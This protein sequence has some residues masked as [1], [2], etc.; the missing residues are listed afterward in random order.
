M[1]APRQRT[2][3]LSAL[4]RLLARLGGSFG[5]RARAERER[6]LHDELES[7]LQLDVDER[8][9]RGVP[10][11]EARR[12]AL[13]ALGGLEAT[14]ERVRDA[15][16][17][18]WLEDLLHDARFALR[19]FRRDRLFFAV[20]VLTFALGIG[21][22]TAIFAAFNAVLL[23]PLP[24]PDGDRLVRISSTDLRAGE[25]RMPVTP[26]DF[27][28]YRDATRSYSLMA[29]SSDGIF[30]FT[31]EG[32]PESIIGYRFAPEMFT[33][34][35]VHPALGRA[36]VAADGAHV[37]VLSDRLWRRRFHS[38]PGVVGRYIRLDSERY[39]VVGVMPQ[40]FNQWGSNE[41]WVPLVIGPDIATSRTRPMIR[42]VARLRP[43]ATVESARAELRT[44]AASLATA[45]PDTNAL[46]GAEVVSLRTIDSGDA[47]PALYVLLGAVV[48]V[49]LLTS[50]NIAGLSLARAS[51]RNREIALRTALGAGRGRIVRQLFTESVL[52]ACIGGAAGVVLALW[53]TDLL[54]RLFPTHT[55]NVH[56]PHIDHIPIDARVLLFGV[57][58]TLL[59]GTLAGLTPAIRGSRIDFGDMLKGGR[60]SVRGSRIRPVLVAAQIGLALV[61]SAGAGL[62]ILSAHAR[63]QRLGFD[64]D[65]VFTARVL[66]D[67]SRYPDEA[68]RRQFAVDL[69][70]RL[71]AT[72]DIR[73]SGL[74]HILPLCG[75]SSP[76][77][78]HTPGHPEE[79]HEAGLLLADAGYFSTMR[80][81]ILRGRS[82]TATDTLTAP[83]VALVDER[84]AR[85]VFGSIEVV[86]KRV[87][88][89]TAKEPDW[90]TIVG[91]VGDV[92]NDPPPQRQRMM[93]YWPFAQDD[94]PFLAVV[95]RGDGEASAVAA[96]VRDAIWAVD[97]EQPISYAMPMDELVA[98]AFALDRTSTI[99]LGFFALVS[100][101]I[102][103]MG[104][105]G[106]LAHTV[107]ERRHEIGIRLALGA[108]RRHIVTLVGRQL[109]LMTATG[110]VVGLAATLAAGRV[111]AALLE[112]V[113]AHDPG[114]LAGI[115][116]LLALVAAAAAALPLWRALRTDPMIALRDP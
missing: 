71:H 114:L 23:R 53:S 84:F 107:L 24:Y 38:D 103:A 66:L 74:V 27:A 10:P 95:A 37:V 80:I 78:Y 64:G 81:P 60:A 100:L 50:S 70:A 111:L 32:E 12:Q 79:T 108:P 62:T 44:V 34:L 28:D 88:F 21:A 61:L 105:Y 19:G 3:A 90:R 69:D 106:V 77:D 49:L 109:A 31:G 29:A 96:A 104:V 87:D 85:H 33:V 47:R 30:T 82:F 40:S 39:L 112:G 68:R 98:D 115:I 93:I 52:L 1:S 14:K 89:G 102:A 63:Q 17:T 57:A 16:R 97:R 15:A 110:L 25:S 83:K 36:F 113:S 41:L 99:I 91:V 18:R 13:L 46:R 51:R 56:I 48:F 92:S 26:A 7:H 35:G 58:A 94:P 43:G 2:R 75:W 86:G 8:I 54:V 4:R 11:D 76:V 20:V 5:G 22:N 65:R 59:A 67:R 45:H 101:V 73:E 6:E 72:R 55:S 116:T 42:I 9:A